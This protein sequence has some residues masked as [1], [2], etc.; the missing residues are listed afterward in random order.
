MVTDKYLSERGAWT[1]LPCR[2][3]GFSEMFDAPS[4]LIRAVFPKSPP[5]GQMSMFTA[6]CPLCGGVQGASRAICLWPMTTKLYPHHLH[7]PSVPGDGSGHKQGP[8]LRGHELGFAHAAVE[9]LFAWCWV[10]DLCKA[11][12]IPFVL[13]HALYMNP[14]TAAIQVPLHLRLDA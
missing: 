11:E 12:G 14:F 5:G 3:C 4:D 8:R 10:G 13:E 1:I 6:F 7:P 9:C 2:K